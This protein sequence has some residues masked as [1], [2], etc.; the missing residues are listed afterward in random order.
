MDPIHELTQL[1][2]TAAPGI[3]AT[4][5]HELRA[6]LAHD[7]AN[8]AFESL[9]QHIARTG[10]SISTAYFSRLQDCARALG[11]PASVWGDVRANV[12]DVS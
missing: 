8:L 4:K 12:L 2:D 7:E 6:L 5:T 9:C 1:V 10:T 3:G 11:I